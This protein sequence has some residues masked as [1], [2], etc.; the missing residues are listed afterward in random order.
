MVY[1]VALLIC[2]QSI[3]SIKEI[4]LGNAWEAAMSL[5]SSRPTDATYAG[6]H[7]M[8]IISLCNLDG[9]I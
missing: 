1:S 3:S 7:S 8:Y 2:M 9:D 4:K 6:Y 5:D